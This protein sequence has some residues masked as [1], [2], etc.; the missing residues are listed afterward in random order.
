M[1][2]LQTKKKLSEKAEARF[3][4]KGAA[5]VFYIIS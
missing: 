2:T 5:G 4:F 1:H 3:A